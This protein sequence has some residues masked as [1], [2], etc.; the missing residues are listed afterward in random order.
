ML[1][2]KEREKNMT[3]E[4]IGNLAE[5][6]VSE[7]W[8]MWR[9]S[10]NEKFMRHLID[11]HQHAVYDIDI[12]DDEIIEPD[13]YEYT[14]TCV[15][16]DSRNYERVAK[17]LLKCLKQGTDF[18]IDFENYLNEIENWKRELGYFDYEEDSL[19]DYYYDFFADNRPLLVVGYRDEG[20]FVDEPKYYTYDEMVEIFNEFSKQNR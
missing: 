19:V 7:H 10:R 2:E 16:S 14:Y 20:D 8:K 4:E 18:R 12:D 6:Y 5:I 13:E 15:L 3:I 11:N 17:K 9:M 1:R